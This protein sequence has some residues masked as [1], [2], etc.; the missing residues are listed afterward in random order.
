MKHFLPFFRKELLELLR[1]GKFVLSIAFFVFL[2]ILNPLTAKML[3]FIYEQMS[4]SFAATDAVFVIPAVSAVDSWT[5]F[6]KNMPIALLI[7]V[8]MFSNALSHEYM[9]GTLIPFLAQGVSRFS[10]VIAKTTSALSVWTIG[11]WLCWGLTY[12]YNEYYWA[13]SGLEGLFFPAFCWYVFGVFVIC[14]E[15]MCITV[16]K[17]STGALVALL[18]IVVSTYLFSIIKTVEQY[19]P[20]V[21]TTG[22]SFLMNTQQ[23]VDVAASMLLTIVIAVLFVFLGCVVFKKKQF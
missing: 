10:I 14:A 21:L 15:I 23:N 4:A 22:M 8:I 17:S 2:G 12:C 16:I 6:Y 3:P 18:G 19:V 1:T 13:N 7:I 11:Y 20:T 5:Q 9:K